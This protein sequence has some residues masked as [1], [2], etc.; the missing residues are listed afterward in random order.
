MHWAAEVSPDDM[1]PPTLGAMV[2]AHPREDGV[3]KEK[4]Y[5]TMHPACPGTLEEYEEY[6]HPAFPGTPEEYEEYDPFP[7]P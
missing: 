1:I 3:P 7:E 6:H 2:V 4:D 5:F